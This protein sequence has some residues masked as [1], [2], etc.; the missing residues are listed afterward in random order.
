MLFKGTGRFTFLP[1][2]KIEQEQLERF[3]EKKSLDEI[4]NSLFLIFADTT[5]LN[6]FSKINF[7][8]QISDIPSIDDYEYPISY[9]MNTDKGYFDTDFMYSI[10]EKLKN[11][12]FMLILNLQILKVIL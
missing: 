8:D 6:Y 12:M 10:L 1:P 9:I 2:S 5:N 11:S 3:Y 4:F 7:T